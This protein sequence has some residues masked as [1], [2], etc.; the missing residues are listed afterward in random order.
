VLSAF[1]EV[2]WALRRYTDAY[3]PRT[4]SIMQ[5]P[6]GKGGSDRFPFRP[7]LIDRLDERTELRARMALLTHEER[8]VLLRWYVEGA[9]VQS[10]AQTMGRSTRHV[11]RL[12]THAIEAIIALGAHDE[13]ADVDLAEF[14]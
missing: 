4:A 3:Q 8:E 12:R 6:T 1:T 13:F 5:T 7:A 10:I 11:Y 14:G 2:E 9:S